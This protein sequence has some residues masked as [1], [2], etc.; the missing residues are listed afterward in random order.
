[1]LNIIKSLVPTSLT[2]LAAS[3]IQQP[4]AQQSAPVE[5]VDPYAT[6]Q[7]VTYPPSTTYP[8]APT[9][10]PANTGEVAPTPVYPPATSTP[11]PTASTPAATTS[12]QSYTI[13][14]G[15]TLFGISRKFNT[16]VDAIRTAN[17]IYD[18][19]IYPGETIV[20]P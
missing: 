11:A 1:M 4:Q 8:T 7:Q 9:Y 13:Q 19:L 10:P 15:D 12:G 18:D 3:C 6:Q 17:S 16:S 20:I 5:K 14:Q 2:L